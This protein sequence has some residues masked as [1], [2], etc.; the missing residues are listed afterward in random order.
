[1]RKDRDPPLT[2]SPMRKRSWFFALSLCLGLVPA[3]AAAV[4]DVATLVGR[5]RNFGDG[6]PALSAGLNHPWSV[7]VAP[8]GS[9][10]ISDKYNVQ[11]RKFD[12]S[13]TI[14]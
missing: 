3:A 11:L 2:L 1:M 13:G 7:T 10:F 8:D 4:G 5:G 9:V 12:P 14:S 6:G